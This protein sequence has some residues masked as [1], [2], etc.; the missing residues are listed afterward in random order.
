[1]KQIIKLTAL[2]FGLI[3]G[4]IIVYVFDLELLVFGEQT[5]ATKSLVEF[6]YQQF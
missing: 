4:Y 2:Y 5:K 3:V 6:V 1:M